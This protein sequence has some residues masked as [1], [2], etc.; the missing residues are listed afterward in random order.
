MRSSK[1][2]MA[3]VRAAAAAAGR[4]AGRALPDG[5]RRAEAPRHHARQLHRPLR[6][7]RILLRLTFNYR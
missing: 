7:L 5:V 4:D 3:C 6:A 1:M 2:G